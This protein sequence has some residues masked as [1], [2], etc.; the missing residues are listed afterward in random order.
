MTKVKRAW[1]IISDERRRIIITDIINYF[2]CERGEK[3]GVIAA[4]EILD[5]MLQTFGS[6]VYNGEASSLNF[7]KERFQSLEI[8]MSAIL[9]K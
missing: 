6:D 1:D 8:D 9:K 2:E 3:M 5:F 4:E 7:L